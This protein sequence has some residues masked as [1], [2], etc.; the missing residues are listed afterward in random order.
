V[1]HREA[2]LQ[3]MD[4]ETMAP[5]DV[6]VWND[7]DEADSYHSWS[8]DGRWVVYGSR[9]LDGRFTRLFIAHLDESGVPC[10]PFLLPQKDPRHNIWRLKSFNVPEFIGGKVEIPEEAEK[11]FYSED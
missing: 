1:W 8:S 3:M 5:V 10:K 9:R 4:L 7:A 2:D 11:L 6:S